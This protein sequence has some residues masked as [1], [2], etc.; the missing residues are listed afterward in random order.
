MLAAVTLSS[1]PSRSGTAATTSRTTR[2]MASSETAAITQPSNP[3]RARSRIVVIGAPSC[4]PSAAAHADS[5]IAASEITE[6]AEVATDVAERATVAKSGIAAPEIAALSVKCAGGGIGSLGGPRVVSGITE[7]GIGDHAANHDPGDGAHKIAHHEA[8]H[9]DAGWHAGPGPL[10]R[11]RLT[12]LGPR[13]E[14]GQRT[15]VFVVESTGRALGRGQCRVQLL[16]HHAALF[17][18]QPGESLG[19]R[20]FDRLRWGRSQEEPVTFDRLLVR[21]QVA[22]TGQGSCGSSPRFIAAKQTSQHVHGEL[23][24]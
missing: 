1:N 12:H 2:P 10:Q 9:A 16:Q 7:E 6:T 11:A 23:L 4:L 13:R 3:T 8:A 5:E 22:R 18:G 19:V 15:W 24:R 21:R 17:R 14:P 20:V